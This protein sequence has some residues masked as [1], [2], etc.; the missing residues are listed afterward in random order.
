MPDFITSAFP[1]LT[2]APPL[3]YKWPTGLRFALAP[4]QIPL[5][6]D[7][8]KQIIHP[9]YFAAVLHRAQTIFESI[10]REKDE[11]SIVYQQFSYGRSR[12][13]K[14]NLIFQY[15][16]KDSTVRFRYSRIRRLPGCSRKQYH[17][18]RVRISSLTPSKIDY[19]GLLKACIYN[20]FRRHGPSFRG[21]CYLFHH[22][23]QLLFHIYDD[24]GMDIVSPH[25][26]FLRK[27]YL[28]YND[29]LLDYDR[30]YM[31]S[32]FGG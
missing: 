7:R 8:A 22:R 29:W 14:R 15:I 2:L 31:D 11:L 3:F 23:H 18:N 16:S 19:H 5:W 24:R 9:H 25:K 12:I 20:D 10:F 21:D 13:S 4:A 1:N 28:E 17:W 26:D 32:L 6:K 30:E 27:L